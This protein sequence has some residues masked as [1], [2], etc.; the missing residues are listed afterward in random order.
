MVL[1]KLLSHCISA[2]LL[3][4]HC[5]LAHD[6]HQSAEHVHIS[7]Q[8]KQLLHITTFV[9]YPENE[10]YPPSHKSP[11]VPSVVQTSQTTHVSSHHDIVDMSILVHTI[12]VWYCRRLRG[13]DCVSP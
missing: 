4:C 6:L 11:S 5:T 7:F 12:V 1:P 2:H 10:I 9:H 8:H 3:H 13:E